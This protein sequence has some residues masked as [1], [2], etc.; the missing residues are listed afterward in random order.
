M[1]WAKCTLAASDE[2]IEND[3]RLAKTFG[4]EWKGWTCEWLDENRAVFSFCR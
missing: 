3:G 2:T 4:N 1:L